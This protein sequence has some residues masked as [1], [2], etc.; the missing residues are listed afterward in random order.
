MIVLGIAGHSD[1]GKTTLL[2]RLVPAFDS[3]TSVAT[4]KSIHHD[5]ELDT[6]GSDTH[7]HATAGAETVVGITPSRTFEVT[8]RRNGVGDGATKLRALRDR[9]NLLR[10]RGVDVVLLEGFHR[11]RC[12]KVV[13]GE[14]VPDG[15]APRVVVRVADPDALDVEEFA[16]SAVSGAFGD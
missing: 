7:R 14:T 12:P 2:D 15:T 3:T 5:I 16:A 1:A 11:V 4:A 13:V 9:L 8:R 6:P 10:A